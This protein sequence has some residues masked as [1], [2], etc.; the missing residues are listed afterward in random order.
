MDLLD[1]NKKKLEALH[2]EA[3]VSGAHPSFLL[4]FFFSLAK[5][6]YWKLTSAG[7]E[8]DAF[9]CSQSARSAGSQ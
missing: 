3:S 8:R 7:K 1:E 4:F 6:S 2:N 5:L 9:C